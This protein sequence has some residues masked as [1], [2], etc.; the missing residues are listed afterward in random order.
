V[1]AKH[2]WWHLTQDGSANSSLFDLTYS[3]RSSYIKVGGKF[4]IQRNR[5]ISNTVQPR[6]VGYPHGFLRRLGYKRSFKKYLA[7]LFYFALSF[8]DSAVS[9]PYD[10]SNACVLCLFFWIGFKCVEGSVLM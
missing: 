7:S 5:D 1:I 3:Q 2:R 4:P 9:L 8:P 6:S 10:S